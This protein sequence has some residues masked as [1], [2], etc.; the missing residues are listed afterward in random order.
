MD[1]R[2][3][4]YM[5]EAGQTLLLI[6][7]AS[8]VTGELPGVLQQLQRLDQWLEESGIDD[9]DVYSTPL[10]SV[11]L[12]VYAGRL[13]EGERRWPG[14]NPALMWHP[15]MWLPPHLAEPYLLIE[16][17]DSFAEPVERLESTDEWAIRVAIELTASGMYDP[18]TAGWVDVLALHDIDIEEPGQLDRIQ[19]WLDGKDDR[20]LDKI[21]LEP[22]VASTEDQTWAVAVAAAMFDDLVAASWSQVATGLLQVTSELRMAEVLPELTAEIISTTLDEVVT[23][24]RVWAGDAVVDLDITLGDRL[25][26]IRYD[27]TEGVDRSVEELIDGP[28]NDTAEVLALVQRAYSQSLEVLNR[29]LEAAHG[30]MVDAGLGE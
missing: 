4:S 6:S 11:P 20:G 17:S 7:G 19:D 9:R 2:R 22:Y 10:V 13:D 12:P 29:T 15:L 27:I 18:D 28:V 25:D 3:R 30:G 21:T 26:D 14:T 16:E 24:G 8:T 5:L 23:M 1:N